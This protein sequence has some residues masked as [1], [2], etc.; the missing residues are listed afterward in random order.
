MQ[1][2][3]FFEAALCIYAYIFPFVVSLPLY[4]NG[5]LFVGAVADFLRQMRF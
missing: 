4:C 3:P 2:V 1:I 5:F